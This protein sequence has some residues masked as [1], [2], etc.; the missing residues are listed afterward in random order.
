MA[1]K[2]SENGI[3]VRERRPGRLLTGIIPPCALIR[4]T[5]IFRARTTAEK[6]LKKAL[7]T[8]L[9]ARFRN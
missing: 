4:R 8:G 3:Y 1:H 9:P 7:A 5:P 2:H 6:R